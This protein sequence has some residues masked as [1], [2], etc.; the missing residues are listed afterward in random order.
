[1]TGTP[2]NEDSNE[3]KADALGTD[4]DGYKIGY[5]K[6]PKRSQYPRGQSGNRR[7]RRKRDKTE[8]YGE[9]IESILMELIPGLKNGKAISITKGKALATTIVDRGIAG[10]PAYEDFLIMVERPD[11]SRRE[12]QWH[13]VEVDTEDEIPP[14]KPQQDRP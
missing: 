7:G 5:G 14:S 3:K 11:L 10:E 6:P 8:P 4:P 2:E 1:M 13:W 12:A 9:L